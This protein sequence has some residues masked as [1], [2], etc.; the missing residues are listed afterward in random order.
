[1]KTGQIILDITG[2]TCAACANRIEKALNNLPGVSKAMVNFAMET[3]SVEYPAGEPPL[4][5]IIAKVRQLGYSASEKKDA[6]N[7]E[8]SKKIE[9]RKLKARFTGAA[10]FSLPLLWTMAEH[11]PLLS[12]VWVPPLFMDGWFQFLLATPVQFIVGYPFY[13]GAFKALRNKGADMNVL[14]A[15]GTSAAYF[16]SLYVMI[17]AAF[18]SRQHVDLYFETSAVLI[19]LIIL[20]KLF[21]ALAKG[22]TSS[23]IKSLMGLQAKTALVF[24]NGAEVQVPVEEVLVG[25]IIHVKP[26]QKIPVDGEII[27]GNSAVDESML[28]GES[29]P[30]EKK[31]GDP[32][33]GATLNKLGF[34]KFKA[35]RVG[36]DT[37]LAQIIR[38]VEEAQ[39]SKAPIQRIADK[40]SGIFV[41][42]VVGISVAT[43]VVWFF[44]I[45]P[46]QFTG[47][48]EKAIAVLVIACPCA[49]GLATP[50][51]I[52]AGSGRAAE[53]GILFKGG[54]YLESAHKIDTVVLD[55]TGTLTRG[56]PQLTDVIP[57]GIDEHSF[58]ELIGSAE[59][60]SEHPLAEA[61]VNGALEKGIALSSALEF[62]SIPGYGI[63]AV[64]KGKT[65]LVGTVKLLSRFDITIEESAL[66]KMRSLEEGG[67]TVMLAVIEGKFSGML[68][69]ADT[70]KD[71]ATESVARLQA[72]GLDVYMITGDNART[73][74]AIA[75]E[76]GIQNVLAEI[77]PKGKADKVLELQESGRTVAMVGDGINDAPALAKADI[78]MALGTGTDVAIETADITLMRGNLK[79]IA[80][81]V[82][83]SRKTMTNIKQNL[84]WALVY[85]SLGIPVA[86]LGFLAPWLAGAAMAMSSVSV[87]LNALR[88]QRIQFRGE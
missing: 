1:M 61:I 69:V 57:I 75:R 51:S 42:V 67:K 18:E 25:D 56:E 31:P 11:F 7:I 70:L 21:E 79:G 2:M 54:E 62:E 22:R 38:V 78:G 3:A 30:V 16:Y 19:S 53:F 46:G 24:R 27:E 37:A 17:R 74:R 5:A 32:V 63:R 80:D 55:K 65:I 71:T 26:G 12:F 35:L 83:M 88:L 81:A 49:L 41:P 64:V 76:A 4:S 33:T 48:L 34:I 60:N 86:A 68:A 8:K 28:T 10:I 73:A 43:F 58:L 9:I 36:K 47:A 50:T 14:V 40:I 20:G 82:L 23:A 66:A 39:G 72:M 85:N 45:E 6:A 29:I 13:A 52:M 59:K 84:F 44:L 87:V 15:L 77:L